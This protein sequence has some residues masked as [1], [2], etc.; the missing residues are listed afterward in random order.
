MIESIICTWC[1]NKT[2][3][4]KQLD[5]VEACRAHNPEVPRSKRGVAI[6]CSNRFLKCFS[7]FSDLHTIVNIVTVPKT[8]ANSNAIGFYDGSRG[9]PAT[10]A[11]IVNLVVEVDH[12]TPARKLL[13]LSFVF[14]IR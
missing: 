6:Q 2:N 3:H 9:L 13:L 8:W 4:S 1:Y 7:S 11:P 12:H 5:A 10:C 14:G